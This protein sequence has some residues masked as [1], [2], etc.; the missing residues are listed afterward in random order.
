[1]N[2]SHKTW[3]SGQGMGQETGRKRMGQGTE[4]GEKG[5]GGGEQEMRGKEQTVG[6]YK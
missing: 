2:H 1:M 5:G 6:K 3:D 4:G